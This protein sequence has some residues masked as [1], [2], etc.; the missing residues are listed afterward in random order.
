M[1]RSWPQAL[2]E[3]YYRD[4]KVQASE[5]PS[6]QRQTTASALERWSASGED[7]TVAHIRAFVDSVRHR[8]T[9]VE[10]ARFGHHAAAC[11]HMINQS[12]KERRVI[13]W[14]A[15]RHTIKI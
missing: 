6:T 8:T 1:V 12:V 2:E 15:A 13:E 11:A 14:D 10:D 4:P 3:A 7:D 5:S 9:P